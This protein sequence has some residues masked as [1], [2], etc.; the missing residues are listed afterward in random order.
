[1]TA[2]K[3]RNPD[4]I[5]VAEAAQLLGLSQFR[6]TRL[7]REGLLTK[8]DGYPSYSRSD[9]QAFIDNPWIN[10]V[11]AAIILGVSHVRVS[12]LA[13]AEKVPVHHTATGRR[14][15][16]LQQL[17]VVAHAR[18]LRFHD[19]KWTTHSKSR[20]QALLPLGIGS[21]PSPKERWAIRHVT[22]E[23][24]TTAPL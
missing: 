14:V 21:C 19:Q 24:G 7:R 10:G 18:G 1:M 13:A 4:A 2:R 9:V 16:R 22:F 11:Q 6:V 17:E 5:T 23:T 8:L 12:Q 15:Y 3:P 20:T